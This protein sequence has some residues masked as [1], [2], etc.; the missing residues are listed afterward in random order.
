MPRT[1]FDNELINRAAAVFSNLDT[2]AADRN[3]G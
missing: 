2:P 1:L 3:L